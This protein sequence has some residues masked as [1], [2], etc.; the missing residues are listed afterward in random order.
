[1]YRHSNSDV[2]WD[3]GMEGSGVLLIHIIFV[4]NL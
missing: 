4:I 3:D 2:Y 1:M